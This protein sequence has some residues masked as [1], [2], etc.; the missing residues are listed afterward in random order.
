M[1]ISDY[2]KKQVAKYWY[3]QFKRHPYLETPLGVKYKPTFR[4]WLKAK[5]IRIR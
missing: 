5:D 4:E 3:S 2:G 1:G